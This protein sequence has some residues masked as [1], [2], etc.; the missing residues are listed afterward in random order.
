VQHQDRA[1]TR[2]WRGPAHGNSGPT[3]RV[4]RRAGARMDLHG[5]E[6]PV[7][8]TRHNNRSLTTGLLSM[9]ASH[10]D[11]LLRTFT[12]QRSRR[13]LPQALLG[14]ALGT[15][16]GMSS[17][18]EA[19]AKKCPP[20]KKRKHGKCKKKKTDGKACSGGTC[21]HGRCVATPPCP[22]GFTVCN[23]SCVD[24]RT[25]E[26]SCGACTAVCLES[27]VCQEGSCFPRSTCS[28]DITSYC[29]PPFGASCGAGAAC[30]CARSAEGNVLCL[31]DEDEACM[32]SAPLC[33][34]SAACPPG[35]AC[36]DFSGCCAGDPAGSKRCLARCP[37][38]MA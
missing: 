20:C 22:Q 29:T 7:H 37:A 34:T 38:P 4:P 30:F 12:E 3:A 17:I 26:A 11:S 19:P 32:G 15:A 31:L 8:W 10:F 5:L 9:D 28:A 24:T 36:V 23:G 6:P 13:R 18:E 14:F 33:E 2:S 35:E 16:I 25:D 1:I 27:Q 21:Q